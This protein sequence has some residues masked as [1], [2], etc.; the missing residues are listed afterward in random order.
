MRAAQLYG[1]R[2]LRVEDVAAPS[3][4]APDEVLLR[5]RACG[6]CPSDLR[7]YMGT[8]KLKGQLPHSMIPGH[9]W[10]GEVVEVGAEVKGFKLGDRVVPSW[11]VDCG[12]CFFCGQGLFNYCEDPAHA[13]V[14][15]GFCEYGVAPASSLRN[16]SD[17][18]SFEEA[19][20]AE[21]LACCIN[22]ISRSRV[23]LGDDV[24]VLGAG[25]IGL[26]HLQLALLLGARVIVSEPVAVRRDMASQLGAHDLIDPSVEDLPARVLDLTEGRGAQAVI[27]AV[28]VPAAIVQAL[29]VA[30]NCGSVNVFAGVYPTAEIVLDPNVIH[31]KQLTVTGSHDFTPHHF[32]T[33]LKL[34]RYRMVKVAPLISHVIPL[35]HA[36]E[37]F[38]LV[39]DKKGSKVVVRME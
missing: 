19:T 28:G 2:N 26:L 36:R 35:E 37:A 13:R 23:R 27:V 7:T 3:I 10:A 33:A 17:N 24:L 12:H 34:I 4:R 38:D 9:E 5:I 14:R 18:V 20:F 39:A 29:Q 31:Y 16:V 15:G 30:A 8:G 1:V 22:G 11:R 25:P 21:P 32:R 6:I